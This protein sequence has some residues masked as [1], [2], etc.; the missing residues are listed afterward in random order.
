MALIITQTD[1]KWNIYNNAYLKLN[2]DTRIINNIISFTWLIYKDKEA[3]DNELETIWNL[4]FSIEI[5]DNIP[6][7][8]KERLALM[9]EK[10][11]EQEEYKNAINN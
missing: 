9:Y 2:P 7:W 10:V 3:R 5:K 6:T 8:D 4:Q 1:N 11:K